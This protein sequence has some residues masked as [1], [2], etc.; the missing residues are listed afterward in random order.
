MDIRDALGKLDQKN[1]AHWTDDGAPRLDALGEILGNAPTREA[2]TEA[3]PKFTRE[4]MDLSKGD[5]PKP[6]EKGPETSEEPADAPEELEP[7]VV[8]A[9][10]ADIDEELDSIAERKNEIDAEIA[11]M[12]SEVVK[13]D[14]V[15]ND[16]RKRRDHLDPRPNQAQMTQAYLAS[17]AERRAKRHVALETIEKAVGGKVPSTAK[18]PIDAVR[19]RQTG[20]GRG[21]KPRSPMGRSD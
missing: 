1:D 8:D 6:D 10:L 20:H 3:A 4:T 14:E 12:K 21:R 15:E 5:D 7:E 16:L 2:V 18:A 19:Q 13:L 17:E 9:E 11:K